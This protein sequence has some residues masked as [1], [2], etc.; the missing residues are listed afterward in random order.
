[1]AMADGAR[2]VPL[3]E[4]FW[5][6]AAR[7]STEG[8]GAI[9]HVA[10]LPSQLAETERAIGDVIRTAAPRGEV[11]ISGCAGLGTFRVRV[12]NASA[13]ETAVATTRLR[14]RVTELAGSVVIARGPAELRKAV[15]PWGPVE[16]GPFALMRAL[17]DEFDAK[18]VLNPGRFVGGL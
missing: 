4:A 5:S 2:I 10:S 16:T 18:R 13:A 1:M 6:R 11:W 15:D 17:K 14:A 12:G 3:P 7:A 9:L 8:N